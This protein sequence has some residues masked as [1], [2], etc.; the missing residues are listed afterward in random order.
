MTF[1]GH[2]I[3][4]TFEFVD[5]N[6]SLKV[7]PEINFGKVSYDF[8]YKEGIILKNTSS[9]EFTYNLKILSENKILQN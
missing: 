8:E 5:P 2:V 6:D 1:L 4:P 7:K 3:A 9:V